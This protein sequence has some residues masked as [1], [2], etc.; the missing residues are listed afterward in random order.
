MLIKI[1]KICKLTLVAFSLF[2]TGYLF[3]FF[4]FLEKDPLWEIRI[5]FPFPHFGYNFMGNDCQDFLW[6]YGSGTG[7]TGKFALANPLICWVICFIFY[8]IFKKQN[9]TLQ[10][11]IKTL[12]SILL[13][14]FLIFCSIS[15]ISFFPLEK[16]NNVNDILIGLPFP[17]YEYR[18]IGENCSTIVKNWNII[19]LILD[20]FITFTVIFVL[21]K[22]LFYNL[23]KFKK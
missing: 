3:S 20:F 12:F 15:F 22:R 4:Y 13:L 10:Q 17:F 8:T 1:S 19:H 16:Q 14:P 5:G 2:S 21:R 11:K 18:Y 9:T 23:Y 7:K 6:G